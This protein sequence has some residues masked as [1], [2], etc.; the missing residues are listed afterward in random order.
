MQHTSLFQRHLKYV[1]ACFY[2]NT[3]AYSV[4]L[5]MLYKPF[6]I[7]SSQH[8]VL[9]SGLVLNFQ[10]FVLKLPCHLAC[11]IKRSKTGYQSTPKIYTKNFEIPV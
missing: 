7:Q 6:V 10:L 8:L 1:L 2:R 9:I 5:Q 11:L 4:A 3:G